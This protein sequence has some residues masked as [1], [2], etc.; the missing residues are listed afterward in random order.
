[1]GHTVIGIEFVEDA[2]KQFFQ[3][4]N[5]KY[6]TTKVDDFIVYKV[7]INYSNCLFVDAIR[8]YVALYLFYTIGRNMS[9]LIIK[10]N[11]LN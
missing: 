4:Q 11:K 5:I 8:V 7:C 3:E 9:E 6:T 10:I 2:L 1:M